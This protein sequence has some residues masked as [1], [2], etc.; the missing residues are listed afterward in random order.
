MIRTIG[1]G[2]RPV[3]ELIALLRAHD[4]AQLADVRT[5]P[6]SRRNPQFGREALAASLAT[7]GIAYVLMPGLGGLR[8]ARPGSRL[9]RFVRVTTIRGAANEKRRPAHARRGTHHS[10]RDPPLARS[11]HS[12]TPVPRRRG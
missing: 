4:M 10:R 3:E 2:T 1:H 7:A 9:L 12:T 5:I 8:K 6:R 11:P